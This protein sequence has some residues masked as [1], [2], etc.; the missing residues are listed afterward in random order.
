M[1]YREL[2]NELGCLT[3][4]QLNQDVTVYLTEQD[5]YFGLMSDYPVAISDSINNDVLDHNTFYLRV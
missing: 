1:T 3:D 4:Q 5:E 2:L